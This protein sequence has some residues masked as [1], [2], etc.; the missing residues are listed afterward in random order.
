MKQKKNPINELPPQGGTLLSHFFFFFFWRT[1]RVFLNWTSS[2]FHLPL[3]SAH[4][5]ATSPSLLLLRCLNILPKLGETS[6]LTSLDCQCDVIFPSFK[7]CPYA[8]TPKS[9]LYQRPE[10]WA[11][12]LSS[13]CSLDMTPA[14]CL[15]T[16]SWDA[17]RGIWLCLQNCSSLCSLFQQMAGPPLPPLS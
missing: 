7:C 4:S 17:T 6:V 14:N 15:G 9:S 8:L 2:L 10:G 3:T 16:S 13:K 11:L 1:C 5:A 12:N